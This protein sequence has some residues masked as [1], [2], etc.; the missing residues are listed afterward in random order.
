MKNNGMTIIELIISILLISLVM[1]FMYK[2]LSNI[3]FEKD[4]DY[5]D[6]LNQ[7]QRVEIIDT[8]SKKILTSEEKITNIEF[9]SNNIFLKKDSIIIYKLTKK[10]NNLLFMDDSK[11]LNN[12]NIKGGIIGDISCISNSNIYECSIPIYT[13]HKDNTKSVVNEIIIDNN[14][15]LDD[16]VLTFTI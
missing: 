9:D 1:L 16:I 11:L 13:K 6:L 5:L 15:T 2:L 10:D 7:E 8:I 12:W 3:T 14:N 4:N